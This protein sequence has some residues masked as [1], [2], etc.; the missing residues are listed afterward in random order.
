MDFSVWPTTHEFFSSPNISKKERDRLL[1]D[2][3]LNRKKIGLYSDEVGGKIV[4]EACLVKAKSYLVQLHGDESQAN[5]KLAFKGCRTRILD[6]KY[7]Y[8]K[9]FRKVSEDVCNAWIIAIQIIS[10]V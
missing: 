2:R 1:S 3:E 10:T 9:R 4:K 8:A 6:I 5:V 7:N